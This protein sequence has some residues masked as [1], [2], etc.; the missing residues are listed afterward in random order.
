MEYTKVEVNSNKEY[1]L[2]DVLNLYRNFHI[3]VGDNKW[4]GVFESNG[5]QLITSIK[6]TIRMYSANYIKEHSERFVIKA[7]KTY[8]LSDKWET[9]DLWDDI[10]KIYRKPWN[11][12]VKEI[13]NT[14]ELCKTEGYTYY[15]YIDD[16]RCIIGVI[17]QVGN[18]VQV[19]S[20]DSSQGFVKFEFKN[21]FN[22][23]QVIQLAGNTTILFPFYIVK[24][25][26]YSVIVC[27]KT[28]KI[29]AAIEGKIFPTDLEFSEHYYARAY[30]NSEWRFYNEHI[31]VDNVLYD[32]ELNE[33]IRLKDVCGN[34]TDVL[35]VCGKYVLINND[36]TLKV[37]YGTHSLQEVS[38]SCPHNISIQTPYL[39]IHGLLH[40]F[41][42]ILQKKFYVNIDRIRWEHSGHKDTGTDYDPY[43]DYDLINDGLDG[44]SGAYWGL[45][46]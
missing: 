15:Y 6:K 28:Q 34:H 12:S 11:G 46:D 32:V 13:N 30:K 45:L 5:K 33:C 21:A 17:W 29:I 14:V 24:L 22:L 44:E 9:V 1:E 37:M 10:E 3:E 36:G 31:W 40:V 7:L 4:Y 39:I 20:K 2:K 35:D 16:S 41:F 43:E 42:D 25:K 18:I 8:C 38:V 23:S 19:L 26:S 27:L